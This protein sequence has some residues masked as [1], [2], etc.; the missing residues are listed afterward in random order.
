MTHVL[1]VEDDPDTG[2]SIKAMLEMRGH[3]VAWARN[4]KEAVA[5]LQ[6]GPTPEVLLTDILMPDMD[7]IETIQHVRKHCPGLP[8][9]AMTAQRHTPYLRAATLFGVKATLQKPF[10]SEE[11]EH[12]L[13][14][15]LTPV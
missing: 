4:G 15:A 7:G 2:E 6:K 3:V 5:K 14:H 12:A 8:M 13:H 9:V 11:L 1:L 10:S